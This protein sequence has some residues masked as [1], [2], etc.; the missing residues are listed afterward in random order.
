M[1]FLF[2]ERS[3]L[4]ILRILLFLSTMMDGDISAGCICKKPGIALMPGSYLLSER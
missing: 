4:F 3:S 2:S 1:W